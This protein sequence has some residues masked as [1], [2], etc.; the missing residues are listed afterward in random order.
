MNS[1]VLKVKWQIFPVIKESFGLPSPHSNTR[2]LITNH[3]DNKKTVKT[4]LKPYLKA[5][6]VAIGKNKNTAY[7]AITKIVLSF[8]DGANDFRALTARNYSSPNFRY[9]TNNHGT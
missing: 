3:N 8:F 6:H 4:I 5:D 9:K 7:M 1:F 2:L